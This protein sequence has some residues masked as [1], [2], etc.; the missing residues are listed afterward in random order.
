MRRA[1]PAVRSRSANTP[2]RNSSHA[3][4]ASQSLPH[5]GTIRSGAVSCVMVVVT[6]VAPHAGHAFDVGS[7]A[8]ELIHER[9]DLVELLLG[10][11]NLTGAHMICTAGQ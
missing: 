9:Q 2:H 3:N 10:G 4:R 6:H 5:P 7:S 8:F 1:P 11:D